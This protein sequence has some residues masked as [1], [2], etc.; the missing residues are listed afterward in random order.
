M[1]LWSA[2]VTCWLA[3]LSERPV[4]KKGSSMAVDS[5]FEPGSSVLFSIS[6]LREDSMAAST[7]LD[8]SSVDFS[9][10]GL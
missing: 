1:A 2:S 8:W 3:S 5:Y 9:Q 4:R 7:S 10:P 6:L